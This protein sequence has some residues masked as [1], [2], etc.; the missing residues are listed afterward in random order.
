[1]R[2]RPP[3]SAWKAACG[4]GAAPGGAFEGK[5]VANCP[6][7]WV[8]LTPEAA[9]DAVEGVHLGKIALTAAAAPR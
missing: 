6:F 5:I 2:G 1:V 3:L 9:A 4:E 8:S 7:G